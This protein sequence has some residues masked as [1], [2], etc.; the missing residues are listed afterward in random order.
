MDIVSQARSRS[1][2]VIAISEAFV[3][4]HTIALPGWLLGI[5]MRKLLWP[6][7]AVGLAFLLKVSLSLLD[8]RCCSHSTSWKA[9]S[10]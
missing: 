3:R 8:H 6:V 4:R 10:D 2:G 9:I 7:S 5:T 1:S